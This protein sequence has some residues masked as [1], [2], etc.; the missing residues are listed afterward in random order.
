MLIA[1][2]Q[3]SAF[4][5]LY[6]EVI[7]KLPVLNNTIAGDAIDPIRQIDATPQEEIKSVPQ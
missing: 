6:Y 1:S 3:V 2:C 4:S 5:L 7:Y